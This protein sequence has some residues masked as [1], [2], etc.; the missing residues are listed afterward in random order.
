MLQSIR[1]IQFAIIALKSF[2]VQL[3]LAIRQ[4]KKK[5]TT[6]LMANAIVS[7]DGYLLDYAVTKVSVHDAKETSVW[8]MC[9]GRHIAKI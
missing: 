1:G 9:F 5:E 8:D 7:D 2:V 4:P 3:T 6:E